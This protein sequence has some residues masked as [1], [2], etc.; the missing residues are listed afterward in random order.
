MNSKLK[1]RQE[2]N[3][4]FLYI[5]VFFLTAAI[6]LATLLTTCLSLRLRLKDHIQNIHL[7]AYSDPVSS[8]DCH[9]FRETAHTV[10]GGFLEFHRTRGGVEIFGY[11]L[12]ETFTDTNKGLIIQ[13]FQRV[14][15]EWHPHNPGP[16]RVVVGSLVDELGYQF[17]PATPEQIPD[18]NGSL[19]YYFPQTGHAVSLV[20][21]DFF[22]QNGGIDI[23][24]YPLSESMYE[25]GYIVQYFQRARMEWHPAAPRDAQ[26]RLTNLGEL[27]IARFGVPK[28]ALQPRHPPSPPGIG[29]TPTLTPTPQRSLMVEAEWPERMEVDRSDSIRVS[30]V[31]TISGTYVPTIEEVGHLAVAATPQINGTPNAPLEEASGRNYRASA[32]ALLGATAFKC[33]SASQEVQPLERAQID[34]VWNCSS[35][36]P[37]DQPVNVSIWIRW[38]PVEDQAAPE[39]RQIWREQLTVSVKK[40]WVTTD[41]LS[42]LSLIS[43]FVGSALS[44]PW[45]YDRVRE[46]REKRQRE[47]ESKPRILLP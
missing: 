34:W 23:F 21:L 12:T 38:D 20:F 8:N 10:C 32:V 40:P 2:L 39:E 7:E 47:K 37:G 36:K 46:A 31:R 15:M 41:Q 45:L 44:V 1:N 6:V 18:T 19:H 29:P 35:D 9:Y 14:R 11:P 26:I 5:G 24:G 16:Y 13:Y 27:Y 43:G 28:D 17:P 22:R 30:L 42:I 3:R 25:N 33:E 4:L